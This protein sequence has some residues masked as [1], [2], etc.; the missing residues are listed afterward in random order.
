MAQFQAFDP[1]GSLNRGEQFAQQQALR[2][3]QLEQ[4]K[5][6][7]YKKTERELLKLGVTHLTQISGSS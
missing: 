1:L 3:I 2:P 7:T 5:Q 6:A 4:A